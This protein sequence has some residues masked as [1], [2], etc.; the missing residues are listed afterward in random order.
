MTRDISGQISGQTRDTG[1]IYRAPARDTRDKPP[2]RV[3]PCPGTDAANAGLHRRFHL[4]GLVPL[5]SQRDVHG[6]LC[7]KTNRGK[8]LILWK[9]LGLRQI[10]DPIWTKPATILAGHL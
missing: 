4:N 6:N 7:S 5:G 2:R 1:D 10:R 3:F 9:R 8:R